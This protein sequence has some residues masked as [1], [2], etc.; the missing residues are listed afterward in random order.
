[1]R[2]ERDMTLQ[3]QDLKLKGIEWDMP[4]TNRTN[5]THN[6]VMVTLHA[7]VKVTQ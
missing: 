2:K 6:R 4:A 3:K 5:F 7:G 1:M